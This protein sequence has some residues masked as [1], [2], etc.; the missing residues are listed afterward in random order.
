F[1][2]LYNRLKELSNEIRPLNI[3]VAY[4]R[5]CSSRLSSDKHHFVADIMHLIGVDLVERKY[6]N[7]NALCC[8]DVLGMAFGYEIKNDV[9]KRNIDDMVEHEAEY[10]VFNCS[11]C[12]NALAIKVAKR[13][14]KPIHI[15]DIC[16]MTI[17]EK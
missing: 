3:K 11:A 10:C 4:Q 8:G 6:Q 2:Y 12:Q 1:E 9:Q 16:R 5:P 14:I 17:G 15:I 7:E 13:G